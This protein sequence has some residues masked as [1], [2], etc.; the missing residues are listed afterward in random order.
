MNGSDV[1]RVKEVFEQWAMYDAVVRNDY[2]CHA[3]LAS[4]LDAWAT[5]FG[6]PLRIIDLGSSDSWLA[7]HAFREAEVDHY[8]GVDLAESSIER[9]RGNVAIWPGR[10]ARLR[11]P[12]RR[13]RRT[14]RWVG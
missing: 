13:A 6:R 2:M 5:R 1:E 9:A 3:E 12:G 10:G 11:K 8:L 4:G 7:T 14:G